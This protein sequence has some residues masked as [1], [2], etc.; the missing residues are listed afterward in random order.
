MQY[1]TQFVEKGAATNQEEVDDDELFGVYP[2]Y[3]ASCGDDGYKVNLGIE[4]HDTDAVRHRSYCDSGT[5]EGVLENTFP[6][7]AATM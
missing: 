3:T 6:L 2:V 1:K 4:G 5:R 7:N